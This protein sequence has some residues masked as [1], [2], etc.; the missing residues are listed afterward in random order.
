MRF[1]CPSCHNKQRTGVTCEKCGINFVKYIGAVVA[2]KQTEQDTIQ[3]KLDRRSAF[4]KNLVAL[5]L[6]GGLSLF[7]QLFR[8]ST[9]KS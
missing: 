3:A 2:A 7:R 6:T 4:L 5:P 9:R 1:E 8:S